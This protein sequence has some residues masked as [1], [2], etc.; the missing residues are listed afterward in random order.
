MLRGA[1]GLLSGKRAP[2][3]MFEIDARLCAR[4]GTTPREVKELLTDCG[5][6]ILRRRRGVLAPVTI[7]EEHEHE[8]LFAVKA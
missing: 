1:R 2:A 8:D 7:D 6:A 3:V 5:Y 4:F